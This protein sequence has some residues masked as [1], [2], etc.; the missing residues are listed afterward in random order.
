M[1]KFRYSTI[2]NIF[3]VHVWGSYKHVW[4]FNFLSCA[5]YMFYDCKRVFILSKSEIY[6]NFL[7]I[8]Q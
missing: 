7:Q 8:K 5:E 1:Q 2:L 4:L 3:T 6:A